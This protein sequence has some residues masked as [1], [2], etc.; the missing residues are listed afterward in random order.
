MGT[1][2][3]P[4]EPRQ[5]IP[6]RIIKRPET[7]ITPAPGSAAATATQLDPGTTRPV[8][9]QEKENDM[10][11]PTSMTEEAVA[12]PAAGLDT[13]PVDD[14]T[15]SEEDS[16]SLAA[17][18]AEGHQEEP[19]AG[20][21]TDDD[22][23]VV[24]S[25]QTSEN[26]HEALPPAPQD[27]SE[28]AVE[29]KDAAMPE[30]DSCRTDSNIESKEAAADHPT[31]CKAVPKQSSAEKVEHYAAQFKFIFESLSAGGDM[32]KTKKDGLQK[33]DKMRGHFKS[34]IMK[35]ATLPEKL[36]IVSSINT[37]I[38][39]VMVKADTL[40]A[41]CLIINGDMA[42]TI[43]IDVPHG[44]WI[45]TSAQVF[46]H[47]ELR[48]LQNAMKLADIGKSA[49]YCHLGVTKLLKLA[50]IACRSPFNSADDPIGM[51]LESAGGKSSFLEEDYDMLAKIAIADYKLKDKGLH[52]ELKALRNFVEIG[53]EITGADIAEMLAMQKLL[54]KNPDAPTPTD[55]IRANS[56]NERKRVYA[57]T[58]KD[59]KKRD[60][61]KGSNSPSIPDINSMFT[62]TRETITLATANFDLK[63]AK[64]DRELYD[65][66]MAD[67]AAFGKKAFPS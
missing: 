27:D 32:T 21:T 31:P 39:P 57:L 13:E 42:N 7:P 44:D 4:G 28:A 11:T 15:V 61:Q 49:M 23:A 24:G 34:M 55:F 64:V 56:K 20:T 25:D 2:F 58:G 3:G 1:K 54:E 65:G 14:A 48:Q 67:L 9:I 16:A 66:L 51:V 45:K 60:T 50:N 6:A 37:A 5:Q 63:E 10:N 30:S 43:K 62:K 12:A 52:I 8:E 26:D 46:P 59:G 47:L 36:N 22:A 29:T 40:R 18:N 53:Q 38:S 33:F 41:I 19:Q 35:N 17:N